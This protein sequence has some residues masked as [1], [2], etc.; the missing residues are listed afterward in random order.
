M[1]I[2]YVIAAFLAAILGYFG[3]ERAVD[4]GN[5]TGCWVLTFIVVTWL[6]ALATHAQG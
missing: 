5:D 4:S 1:A 3:A 2:A 6:L